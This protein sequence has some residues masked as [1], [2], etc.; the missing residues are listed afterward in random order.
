MRSCAENQLLVGVA[1]IVGWKDAGKLKRH[2][3]CAGEALTI[4]PGPARSAQVTGTDM[5]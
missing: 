5:I 2:A 3:V 4:C 1:G